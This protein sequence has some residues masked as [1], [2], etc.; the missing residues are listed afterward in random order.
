MIL[1]LGTG[2]DDEIGVAKHSRLGENGSRHSDIVV[3]G[4]YPNERRGRV[5]IGCKMARELDPRFRFD[6][7]Y[8][9]LEHLVEQFDLLPGMPTGPGNEQ[10][11][12]AHKRRQL[13]FG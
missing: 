9:G 2:A 1:A 7:T 12:D 13:L 10:I 4:K 3:K 8:E 11:G 6:H 5:R